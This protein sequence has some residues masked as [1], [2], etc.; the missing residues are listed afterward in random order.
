MLAPVG[1]TALPVAHAAL[2][3]PAEPVAL[4]DLRHL[5]DRDVGSDGEASLMCAAAT[6]RGETCET[7][8]DSLLFVRR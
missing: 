3:R 8:F 6:E 2:A 1:S 7:L 4:E 5:L